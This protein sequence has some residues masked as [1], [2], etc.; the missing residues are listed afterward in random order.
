M[1]ADDPMMLRRAADRARARP[2]FLGWVLARFEELE[3][4]SKESLY[5][6]LN[7]PEADWPRLQLCLRPRADAFLPDVTQ[8]A[9]EFGIDR[10]ALAA[11]IRRVEAVDTIRQRE[12]P[13]TAGNMLAARTRKAKK[14][15]SDP[16]EPG[17]E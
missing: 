12:Q 13:G 2:E 7:V 10:A 9:Q 14:R 6:Q 3:K 1:N 15:S 17:H 16:E 5:Q 4:L 8:I 11:V